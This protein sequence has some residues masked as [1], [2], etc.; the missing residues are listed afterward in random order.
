MESLALM[1]LVVFAGIVLIAP[2]ASRIGIPVNIAEILRQQKE[3][4][5]SRD[6]LL[7]LK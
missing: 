4:L 1:L 7:L 2:I 6:K 5:L 3:Q